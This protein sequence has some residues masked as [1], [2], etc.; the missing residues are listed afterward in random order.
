MS[1]IGWPDASNDSA[2]TGCGSNACLRGMKERTP[3]HGRCRLRTVTSNK[4]VRAKVLCVI[5]SAYSEKEENSFVRCENTETTGESGGERNTFLSGPRTSVVSVFFVLLKKMV[6]YA[7]RVNLPP[8]LLP[9]GLSGCCSDS[10]LSEL[11]ANVP[12]AL[13]SCCIERCASV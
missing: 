2:S 10:P 7:T 3:S 8:G 5:S 12:S 9:T 4:M 13:F 1:D 6:S 11:S